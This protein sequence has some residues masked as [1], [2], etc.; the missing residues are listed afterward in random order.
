MVAKRGNYKL[1][2][3][4]SSFPSLRILNLPR[5]GG[6]AWGGGENGNYKLLWELCF[7][8]FSTHFEFAALWWRHRTYGGGEKGNHKLLWEVCFFPFSKH[9]ELAALRWRHL[10]WRRKR[11]L[12]TFMGAFLLSV[13]LQCSAAA[14]KGAA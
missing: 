4:S 10:G 3:G 13:S 9:F 12:Q 11:K 7:L 6:A 14:R 2:W 8:P 5:Y 1:L